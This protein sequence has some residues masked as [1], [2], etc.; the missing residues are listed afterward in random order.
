MKIILLEDYERLGKKGDIVT[1]KDGYARNYLIPKGIAI[2]ATDKEI[3]EIEKTKEELLARLERRKQKQEKLAEK[4]KELELTAQ[5]K[6]GRR[7]AFGAITNT[8]IAELLKAQGININR[9]KII[10]PRP[11]KDPGIYEIPVN[12]GLIK[13]SVKLNVLSAT[14][15]PTQ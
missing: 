12:L 2:R 3:S 11:I 14:K 10:L 9:H 13:A 5:L 15:G 8:D 1:V 7:G 6:M 4:L